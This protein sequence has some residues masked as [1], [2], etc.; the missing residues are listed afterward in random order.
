MVAHAGVRH[1]AMGFDRLIVVITKMGI[2]DPGVGVLTRDCVN[3]GAI[4]ALLAVELETAWN[5][6]DLQ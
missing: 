6:F 1:E 3:F 4:A 5:A 2:F